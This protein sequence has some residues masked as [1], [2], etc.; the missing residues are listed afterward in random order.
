MNNNKI[1]YS[2]FIELNKILWTQWHILTIIIK[3]YNS[4]YNVSKLYQVTPT[5][6]VYRH[7][8]QYWCV[9][10]STRTNKNWH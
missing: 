6:T 5:R 7:V 1:I 9:F 4:C 8:T 2:I 3:Y 10:T